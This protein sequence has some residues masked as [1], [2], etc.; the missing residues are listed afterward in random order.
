MFMM[1][2]FKGVLWIPPAHFMNYYRCFAY[3]ALL[4]GAMSD[5]WNNGRSGKRGLRAHSQVI[6]IWCMMLLDLAL[7][8]KMGYHVP[9]WE[10]MSDVGKGLFGVAAALTVYSFKILL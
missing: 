9:V 4:E 10:Q 1:F 6:L 5:A 3:C 8:C 7:V 2:G